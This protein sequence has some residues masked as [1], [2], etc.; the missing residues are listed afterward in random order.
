MAVCTYSR[1]CQCKHP[2]HISSVLSGHTRPID[3]RVCAAC[4][5]TWM[6]VTSAYGT[7]ITKSSIPSAMPTSS[8][9]SLPT[10]P[11]ANRTDRAERIEAPTDAEDRSA[12]EPRSTNERTHEARLE[13]A[14]DPPV[15]RTGAPLVDRDAE[16]F[17]LAAR[18]RMVLAHLERNRGAHCA[19]SCACVRVCAR[20]ALRSAKCVVECECALV[21][22]PVRG[23]QFLSARM[24][25]RPASETP[26]A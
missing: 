24:R 8:A 2:R 18:E 6:A 12:E 20:V 5:P 3:L 9:T 7:T 25:A 10:E 19:H 4:A 15:R 26:R 14:G 17:L 13:P 1:I 11:N 22:T 16:A 23:V 21:S